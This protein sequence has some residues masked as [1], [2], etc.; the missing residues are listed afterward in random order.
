MTDRRLARA[1]KLLADKAAA[2]PNSRF[3]YTTSDGRKCEP[4]HWLKKEEPL[5]ITEAGKVTQIR[6]KQ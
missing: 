5:V 2:A 4:P 1:R 3:V 6:G